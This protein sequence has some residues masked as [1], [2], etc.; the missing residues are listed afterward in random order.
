MP[1][2][3]LLVVGPT[4]AIATNRRKL[5]A[6]ADYFEMACATSAF[7]SR[8]IYGR[9]MQ[10]FEESNL[11]EPIEIYRFKEL[12]GNREHTRFI[13]QGLAGLLASKKFEFILVENEP[14][15]LLKWQTWL[16]ARMFQGRALF[17]EFSWENVERTGF[18]GLFLS[19]AY[20]LSA[21]TDHFVVCGNEASKQIFLK[22][23]A[24]RKPTLVA[25]QL[26]VDTSLFHPAQ[27]AE[28]LVL[29][30]SQGLPLDAILVGYCGRLSPEKGVK[31]LYQA[32]E[33]IRGKHPEIHLAILGNGPCADEL[34]QLGHS[35][36]HLFGSRPHF[37]IPD[38]IRA[39]DI[40]VLASKPLREHGRFWEEQFG[41]VLIESMASGVLTLG[42]RSGAIPEVLDDPR[43]L[44]PHSSAAGIADAL[45]LY[46]ENPGLR[47]KVAEMQ[48]T[49][50]L[51]NYSHAMVAKRYA[52]FLLGL[53][54]SPRDTE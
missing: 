25:P 47:E 34:M 26:G 43:L 11:E 24:A 32:V 2:Q 36:I 29:R 12:P 51:E 5:W 46:V 20:R 39:L 49:R 44:F 53:R 48:R 23:G 40:F 4:Y 6:L 3:R 35:W 42:S 22:Y 13:Y 37:E 31:D 1:K 7:S 28:R 52:E 38:F 33:Q 15:G 41:H 9:P 14:W 30:K 16:F 45:Q 54:E 8:R 50:V 19:W 21:W 17:G 18:R 10:D 27:K